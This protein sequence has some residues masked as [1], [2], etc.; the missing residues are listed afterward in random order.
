[1][2]LERFILLSPITFPLQEGVAGCIVGDAIYIIADKVLVPQYTDLEFG[3]YAEA[4]IPVEF[5]VANPKLFRRH[6]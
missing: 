2:T 1:M 4:R 3:T 6:Q 5:I